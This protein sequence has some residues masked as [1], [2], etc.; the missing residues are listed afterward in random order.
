MSSTIDT[1]QHKEYI[2]IFFNENKYISLPEPLLL[3]SFRLSVNKIK[4]LIKRI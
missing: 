2:D 1:T 4:C 3:K